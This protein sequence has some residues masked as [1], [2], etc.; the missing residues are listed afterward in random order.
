MPGQVQRSF[1]A[2]GDVKVALDKVR[3]QASQDAQSPADSEAL[4]RP[5]RSPQNL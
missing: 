3:N 1:E 2:Y 4:Q 5:L